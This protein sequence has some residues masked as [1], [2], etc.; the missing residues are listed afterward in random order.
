MHGSHACIRC[1][2]KARRAE[3]TPTLNAR[4]LHATETVLPIVTP[5][6][7]RI[8]LGRCPNDTTLS[9]VFLLC[10]DAYSGSRLTGGASAAGTGHVGMSSSIVGNTA[11]C[12]LR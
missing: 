11:A 12:T 2:K 8:F 9:D 10:G 3:L 6:R 4:R 7:E 1:V 5:K